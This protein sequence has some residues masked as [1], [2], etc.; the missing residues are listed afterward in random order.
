VLKKYGSCCNA[1]E[2]KKLGKEYWREGIVA[3]VPIVRNL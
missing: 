1:E 3:I 2:D